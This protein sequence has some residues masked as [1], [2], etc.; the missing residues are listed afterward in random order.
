MK[1]V[2]DVFAWYLGGESVRGVAIR[3]NRA[4]RTTRDGKPWMSS[5]VQQM[6]QRIAYTGTFK[7]NDKRDG[8]YNSISGGKV[9]APCN[10][11]KN[12]D[13]LIVIPDNHPAIIDRQTFDAAR[14]RLSQRKRRTTPH[15]NGGRFLLSG[16]VRCGNCGG[17][18]AGQTRG[19]HVVRYVCGGYTRAGN[20]EPN[21]VPQDERLEIIVDAI[22]ER[23]TNPVA[24]QQMRDELRRQVKATAEK[25][26]PKTINKQL[27]A[28]DAKLAKAKERL[29]EV[30]ADLVPIVSDK[31]RELTSK[32]DEL[33]AALKAAQI[34]TKTRLAEA[35]ASVDHAME[36]FSRLRETLDGAD[37]VR[38]RELLSQIVQRVD[39]W[40]DPVMRG[41]RRVFQL[42]RGIVHLRGDRLNNLFTSS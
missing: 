20:C 27:T 33:K 32:R 25:I 11:N 36:L 41:R 28:V 38:L 23:F 22:V 8:K 4:G 35:D 7:W 3:L 1:L 13:D 21:T 2:R 30:E 26:T 29:I 19:S 18:M 40:S 31:I 34:P 24:I 5:V 42:D 16:L 15:V 37:T 6:L 10:G 9:C 14:Q 39:V 17:T 12:A